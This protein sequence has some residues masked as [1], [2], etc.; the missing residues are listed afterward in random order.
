MPDIQLKE[1][2]DAQELM[3]VAIKELQKKFTDFEEKGLGDSKDFVKSSDYLSFVEKMEADAVKFDEQTKLNNTPVFTKEEQ[4]RENT[5]Q[6]V[7]NMRAA[8]L[9]A[10]KLD[11]AK[12][13]I[14]AAHETGDLE[15]AGALT[16]PPEF[17][18]E[19]VDLNR[20]EVSRIRPIADNIRSTHAETHVPTQTAHG[21]AF[22]ESELG[23]MTKNEED[24]FGLIKVPVHKIYA[25]SYATT[26]ML[27][28]SAFNFEAH[29]TKDFGGGMAKKENAKFVN[30]TGIDEPLGFMQATG[31][32]EVVSGHATEI[33]ADTLKKMYYTPKDDYV[34]APSWVMNRLTTYEISILK[35]GNGTYIFQEAQGGGL[36]NIMGAPIVNAQ[37]M[38]DVGA[39]LYPIAFGDWKEGY[40]TKDLIGSDITIKDI[41]SSKAVGTVEFLWTRRVGGMPKVKEAIKK[42]KISLT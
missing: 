16:K 10:L 20:I 19:I 17:M 23:T 9:K 22:F 32:G 26:E 35:F 12:Y 2:A 27:Q 29:L 5:K 34:K 37:D 28:D 1:V 25:Y 41:Y 7:E 14:K 4:F 21:N 42:Y 15:R 40:V 39:G 31:I 6:V 13:G 38:P 24:K 36:F 11:P 30:G 8:G 33:Q 18:T 3:T